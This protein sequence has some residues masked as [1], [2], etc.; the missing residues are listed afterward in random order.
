MREDNGDLIKVW[1]ALRS[2]E[3]IEA[4]RKCVKN[5]REEVSRQREHLDVVKRK[6]KVVPGL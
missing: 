1:S 5:R 6:N 3:V 2:G 4:E